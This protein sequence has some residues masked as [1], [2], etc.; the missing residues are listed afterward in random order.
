MTPY[1]G[2]GGGASLGSSDHP[3]KIASS[4]DEGIQS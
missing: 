2:G 4:D 1:A 3:L